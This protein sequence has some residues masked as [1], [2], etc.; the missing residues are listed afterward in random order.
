MTDYLEPFAKQSNILRLLVDTN[1]RNYKPQ[2]KLL[3]SGMAFMSPT[4]LYLH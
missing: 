4:S 1:H 3:T 2:E